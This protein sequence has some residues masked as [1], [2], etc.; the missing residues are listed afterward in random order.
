MRDIVR[1]LLA[2]L[3]RPPLFPFL[4]PFLPLSFPF[5]SPFLPLP[6]LS[7]P[8]SPLHSPPHHIS[9]PS[10]ASTGLSPLAAAMLAAPTHAVLGDDVM[11]EDAT[12]RALEERAAALLGKDA[13]LFLPTGCMANTVALAVHCARGEELLAGTRSHIFNWEAGAAATLLGVAMQPVVTADNGSMALTD[14]AAAIRPDDVHC[15]RTRLVCLEN[16]HNMCGGR[17]LPQEY[18]QAV[19]ALCAA[20]GLSLHVD[21]ARVANASVALGMSLADLLAPADTVSLC[22]SKGL[23]APLGSI[24]AGPAALMH[25]ARYTRKLLGGGMRQAGFVAAAGHLALDNISRLAEDH[26][27]AR[28][29]AEGVA[30]S[31]S[32]IVTVAAPVDTNIV[33]LRVVGASSGSPGLNGSSTAPL[34]ALGATCAVGAGDVHAEEAAKEAA[35][36]LARLRR[37]HGVLLGAADRP[38]LIRAVFHLDV[39]DAGVEAAVDAL[40]TLSAEVAQRGA[41][42]PC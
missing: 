21:G 25:R 9:T 18:M 37:D 38:G 5:H 39:D 12:V 8:P 2:A 16:T 20:R 19:G 27:R 32:N 28:R 17:V 6:F 23:G 26:T 30:S 10:L 33:L 29:F 40:A 42:A 4:S 15:A 1:H 7:F 36:I 13:A 22:L 41:L 34:P 11:R 35:A 3:T 31:A 24:L 14:M